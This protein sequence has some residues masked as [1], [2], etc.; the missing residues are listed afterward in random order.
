LPGYRFGALARERNMNM[1]TSVAESVLS[2]ELLLFE[3][4]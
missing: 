3:A 2:S 1:G 4:E